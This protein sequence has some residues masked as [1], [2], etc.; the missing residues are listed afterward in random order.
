M[1]YDWTVSAIEPFEM[2]EYVGLAGVT[3]PA[4]LAAEVLGFAG[5]VVSFE[6]SQMAAAI[7]FS[8]YATPPAFPMASRV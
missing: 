2:T 6:Y 3:Y 8:L 7:A 5:V 1:T 4:Y